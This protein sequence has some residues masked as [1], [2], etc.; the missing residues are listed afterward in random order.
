MKAS[1]LSKG[2]QPQPEPLKSTGKIN[3]ILAYWAEIES[4][5]LLVSKRIRQQFEK[6]VRQ[7][8]KPYKDYVFDIDR[9][10]RPIHY[11]EDICRH[12]KGKFGSKRFLLELWQK[13]I[14]QAVFG[15]VH[16]ETG[17]RQYRFVDI[18]VGRK[19]G[20][21]TLAAAIAL[22]MLT[23]D[24]EMGA[25]IYS[26]ATKKDQ[27]KVIWDE[28][29]KMAGQSPMLRNRLNRLVG[30]IMY[31]AKYAHFKPLA[32]EQNSL[33]GLNS[34]GVFVDELHAIKDIELINVM[35]ESVASREQPIVWKFTTMGFVRE[36]A[37]DTIY[38]RDCN[39]LDGLIENDNTLAFIYEL[40]KED[41][42]QDERTWIKAN[43]NLGVSKSYRFIKDKVELAKVSKSERKSL[44]CKDFNLR[45]T[46]SEAWLSFAQI[47]NPE[48]FDIASMGF[49]YAIGGADL[50][51]TTD[52]TAAK[53]LCMRPNDERIYVLQMYFMPADSIE[54][55][56][57]EDGVPYDKWHAQGLL[58]ACPGNKINREDVTAWF[59]EMK[60]QHEIYLYKLGYDAWSAEY[61]VKDMEMYFGKQCLKAVHQGKKTLSLPMKR[62]GKDLEAKRIVYNDHP[63]DKW[64]LTNTSVDIDLK[65]HTIQPSKPRNR[66]Q[67]I[68]GTAALL[69]AYTCL[70]DYEQEYRT[71]IG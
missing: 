14:I 10:T 61:W 68:D 49:T 25:E 6:L 7:L 37:F 11:I 1:T 26:I 46:A 15:F 36:A 55:R 67:R 57:K 8:K 71:M 56:A 59:R 30:G 63:I 58:R 20:K 45:E 12:S 41:D 13:A 5:R 40:D 23:S 19:N 62:L 43:P 51:D 38:L 52:L 64:C 35:E 27:A 2:R 31:D 22:Y 60:D 66:K 21:S 18:Y 33:D 24:D 9:A 3:Y 16:K 54:R 53:L 42:W 65:N 4:G 44:M 48:K 34:H 39:I 50:S 29:K 32:S 69:N 28:A 17:L 70:L 47:E